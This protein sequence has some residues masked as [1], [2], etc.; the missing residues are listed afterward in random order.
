[1]N[2][3]AEQPIFTPTSEGSLNLT[4]TQ[5]GSM[6]DLTGVPLSAPSSV[7]VQANNESLTVDSISAG[8]GQVTLTSGGTL[9]AASRR[10]D[11]P[12]EHVRR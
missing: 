11:Q 9:A 1:M 8:S 12:A 6:I 7:T 5:S 3:G 10:D 4:F 2:A